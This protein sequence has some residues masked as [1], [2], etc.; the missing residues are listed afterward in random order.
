M[1]SFPGKKIHGGKQQ[2]DD[3]NPDHHG[4]DAPDIAIVEVAVHHLGS[5]GLPFGEHVRNPPV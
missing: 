1:F 2:D 5:A 4:S 3:D